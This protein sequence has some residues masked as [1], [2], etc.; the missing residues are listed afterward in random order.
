MAS[1]T[2]GEFHKF[3]FQSRLVK[4]YVGGGNGEFSSLWHGVFGIYHQIH[5]YLVHYSRV[6]NHRPEILL[7]FDL[8]ANFFPQGA[9]HHAEEI[10]YG[11]IEVYH[12]PFKDLSPGKH[13]QLLDKVRCPADPVLNLFQVFP[14]LFGFVI[15][16]GYKIQVYL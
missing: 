16:K 4:D 5:D 14:C 8:E 1:I 13:E 7:R 10:V 15:E 6:C 3:F 9:F 2:N 11:L 12:V